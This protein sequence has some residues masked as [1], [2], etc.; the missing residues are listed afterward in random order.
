[1]EVGRERKEKWGGGTYLQKF[2]REPR[3]GT[4]RRPTHNTP[5]DLS[6]EPSLAGEGLKGGWGQMAHRNT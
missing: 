1:M 2:P 4:C 3:N 5:S 6:E